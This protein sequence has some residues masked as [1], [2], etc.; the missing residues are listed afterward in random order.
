MPCVPAA[1]TP[2]E[3]ARAR[4][5]LICQCS[6]A[7]AR[8]NL[9]GCC[10]TADGKQL[11]VLWHTL[12]NLWRTRT[13]Y[14]AYGTISTDLDAIHEHS[15]TSVQLCDTRAQLHQRSAMYP[16]HLVYR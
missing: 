16:L 9:Y 12:N 7:A 3:Y 8:G 5:A 13:F 11:G 10:A 6:T 4:N 2:F 1:R 14:P 15:S